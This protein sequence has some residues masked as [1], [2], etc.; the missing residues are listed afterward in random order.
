[1][2]PSDSADHLQ[3]AAGFLA[4]VHTCISTQD[5]RQRPAALFPTICVQSREAELSA[6]AGAPQG[7]LLKSCICEV[8]IGA[9]LLMRGKQAPRVLY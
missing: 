9:T 5:K 3:V 8:N 7:L 1:M 2:V 6:K 4:C